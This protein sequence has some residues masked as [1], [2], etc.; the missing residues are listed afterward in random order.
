VGAEHSMHVQVSGFGR[1]RLCTRRRH[2]WL[3]QQVSV[4]GWEHRSHEEVMGVRGG[5]YSTVIASILLH[6][7]CTLCAIVSGVVVPGIVPNRNAVM[8]Q[9]S[10]IRATSGPGSLPRGFA[11]SHV[12]DT[13]KMRS[14][15]SVVWDERIS[16][17][18]YG[19]PMW[20]RTFW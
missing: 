12:H 17:L 20:S 9:V 5:L 7:V 18:K 16:F 6:T 10:W 4:S 11:L 1:Q 14:A 19:V 8:A 15:N 3:E 13:G 2:G